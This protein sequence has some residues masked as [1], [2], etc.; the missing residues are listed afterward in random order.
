[1]NVSPKASIY[2]RP[3][4]CISY[5]FGKMIHPGRWNHHF[6]LGNHFQSDK[7]TCAILFDW[8]V[9]SILLH[10]WIMPSKTL[11]SPSLSFWSH[12]QV[13]VIHKLH[14][15]QLGIFQESWIKPPY[16]PTDSMQ[17]F[18]VSEWKLLI[19]LVTRLS[20]KVLNED[21]F[22]LEAC[23]LESLLHT[24][25]CR[26]TSNLFA[27]FQFWKLWFHVGCGGERKKHFI[28]DAKEMSFGVWENRS[29][30]PTSSSKTSSSTH[31]LSSYPCIFSLLIG[32]VKVLS[33]YASLAF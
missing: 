6:E 14:H 20:F 21:S 7:E 18:F 12:R 1:M 17:C 3:N 25:I 10:R 11:W 15:R 28:N 22:L 29:L 2:I 23:K 24:K 5:T 32:Q 4:K 31:V 30:A 13:I 27:T 19:P 9:T 26:P 8:T 33:S 16:L